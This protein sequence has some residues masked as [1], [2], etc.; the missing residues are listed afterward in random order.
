MYLQPGFGPSS[1]KS[2]VKNPPVRLALSVERFSSSNLGISYVGINMFYIKHRYIS[3][4]YNLYIYITYI[5]ICIYIGYIYIEVIGI[6]IYN[7][8]NN[9]HINPCFLPCTMVPNSFGS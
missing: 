7:C 1:R 8:E 9:A 4:I 5:Y 2:L 3:Y 6:Y